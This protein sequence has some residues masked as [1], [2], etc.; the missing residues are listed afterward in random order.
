MTDNPINVIADLPS[1]IL[2]A[3]ERIKEHVRKTPL[4]H[5]PFLSQCGDCYIKLGEYLTY[6]DQN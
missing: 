1:E 4:M 5:S 2:K 6:F 3:R